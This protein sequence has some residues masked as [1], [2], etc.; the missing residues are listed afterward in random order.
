MFWPCALT[1]WSSRRDRIWRQS[2]VICFGQTIQFGENVRSR[3]RQSNMAQRDIATVPKN[4][5]ASLF[6]LARVALPIADV[7]RKMVEPFKRGY[8]AGSLLHDLVGWIS[9]GNSDMTMENHIS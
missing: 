6:L 8:L 4:E 1:H 5:L 2:S 7:R 9:L 3:L